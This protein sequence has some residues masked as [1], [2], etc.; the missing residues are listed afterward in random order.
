MFPMIMFPFLSKRSKKK[1][2]RRFSFQIFY[3]KFQKGFFLEILS[4]SYRGFLLGFL[5][6]VFQKIFQTFSSEIVLETHPPEIS[7]E[8]PPGSYLFRKFH[9][10]LMD[11][12]RNLP[13]NFIRNLSRN[14][15]TSYFGYLFR[16]IF[17]DAYIFEKISDIPSGILHEILQKIYFI[18]N[19]S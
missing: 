3:Q 7:S 11:C 14:F 16:N 9:K 2:N 19:F 13:K 1:L 15:C 5:Q 12:F 10:V 4:R 18:Y 6:E 8:I 17:W